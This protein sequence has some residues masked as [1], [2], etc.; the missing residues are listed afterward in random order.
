[1]KF[2][3]LAASCAAFLLCSG[4]AL[5]QSCAGGSTE[6]FSIVEWTVEAGDNLGYPSAEI[7]VTLKNEMETGFRMVDGQVQFGDALGGSIGAIEIPRTTGAAASEQFEVAGVYTSRSLPTISEMHPDDVI[8]TA[9]VVGAISDAGDVIEHPRAAGA[10]EPLSAAMI[11]QVQAAA[12][13][14][15]TPPPGALSERIKISV[16]ADMNR[17]GTVASQQIETAL[18]DDLIRSTAFAAQR[19]VERCGPY[20]MLPPASYEEWQTLRFEFDV[21]DL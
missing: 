11:A 17:D 9:C 14:C 4:S 20:T 18:T 15:W 16:I 19:A 21:S 7:S 3:S 2:R 13:R 10:I 1:M 8:V 12:R 5:A 6:A